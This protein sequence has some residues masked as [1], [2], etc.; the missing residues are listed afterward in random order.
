M[1]KVNEENLIPLNQRTK[2]EQ[3]EIAQ[4]GG[5]A[6]GE[7]RREKASLRRAFEILFSENWID[8]ETGEE[9]PGCF[10]IALKQFKKA[11]EGDTKAFEII[12]DTIGQKPV[13]RLITNEIPQDVIDEVEA[14][15]LEY[16][17]E[18]KE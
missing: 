4:K 16:E 11:M 9:L 15:I 8:E 12:R 6:S 17:N 2:S 5:I 18:T 1:K 7:S 13:D 3:R 10:L 14:M